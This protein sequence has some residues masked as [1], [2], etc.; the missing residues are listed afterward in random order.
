MGPGN[1]GQHCSSHRKDREASMITRTLVFQEM[2][3]LVAGG[4]EQRED[5]IRAEESKPSQP[6]GTSSLAYLSKA[7]HT[8]M[9]KSIATAPLYFL[10][11]YWSIK[12]FTMEYSWNCLMGHKRSQR[13]KNTCYRH[14]EII[15][16]YYSCHWDICEIILFYHSC[17]WNTHLYKGK[18]SECQQA[19]KASVPPHEPNLDPPGRP[20]G[21][22]AKSMTF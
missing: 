16:F 14:G 19:F 3:R 22:A 10:E 1:H 11:S 15:L 21:Q 8:S 12:S 2:V 7:R 20:G 5:G 18:T 6:Q 17:H 9:K 4:E 13:F